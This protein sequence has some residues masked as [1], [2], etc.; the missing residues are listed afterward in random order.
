VVAQVISASSNVVVGGS[1]VSEDGFSIEHVNFIQSLNNNFLFRGGIPNYNN[2]FQYAILVS[3]LQ[4]MAK[5]QGYLS[6]PASFQLIDLNLL[7]PNSSEITDIKIEK[8]YFESNPTKGKFIHY[9]I[10]GESTDPFN[11]S[12]TEIQ[13]KALTF[14]QWSADKLPT[15]IETIRGLVVTPSPT[16]LVTYV[17]CECGCDR[18]GEVSGAY[19]MAY[20]NM[21]LHDAHEL[22]M[23]I[24]GRE[25]TTDNHYALNWY[26]FY[27]KYV[28][29]YQLT[30][31]P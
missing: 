12:S 31:D 28:R 24:A 1:D 29:N 14:A 30:C 4:E 6:L 26:C 5:S 27:L 10:F 3:Q 20:M 17:H 19:Y 16:P 11:Y 21:S 7:D 13:Q 8:A 9:Q 25:I 2:T 22:D 15:F 18:T 23:K